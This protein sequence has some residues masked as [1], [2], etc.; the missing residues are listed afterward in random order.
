MHDCRRLALVT[1]FWSALVLNGCDCGRTEVADPDTSVANQSDDDPS[2]TV[3]VFPDNLRVDDPSVNTFV[4][5]AMTVCSSRDYDAFRL[6]W[7]ARHDPLSRDE[8]EAGWQAVREI[9]I[10]ALD[11]A[12]LDL[13]PDQDG[14]PPQ[15]VYALF[16][17]VVLDPTHEAA[18]KKPRREVVLMIVKEHEEWR[19]AKAPKRM[20]AWMTDKVKG[21]GPEPSPRGEPA[22]RPDD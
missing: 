17:Q 10:R 5:Q 15:T 11:R 9:R 19:L 14:T 12:K 2:A 18:R 20:R 3:L 22:R 7:S 1:A 21:V 4:H 13:S 16:A 8:F 6:L